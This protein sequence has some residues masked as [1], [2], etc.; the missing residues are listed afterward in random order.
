[1]FCLVSVSPAS[2]VDWVMVSYVKRRAEEFVNWWINLLDVQSGCL[3]AGQLT[4]ILWYSSLPKISHA[5]PETFGEM[6]TAEKLSS[7]VYSHSL[8]KSCS[9]FSFQ[10][11][12][13]IVVY[14]LLLC[15]NFRYLGRK[16][17]IACVM[18][19]EGFI[20]SVFITVLQNYVEKHTLQQYYNVY[21][22]LYKV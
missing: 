13:Y 21:S 14:P 10:L 8:Y 11:F 16:E 6:S 4:V 3:D 19:F 22:T 1:M 2:L 18:D 5:K 20:W 15:L 9:P 17:N 12:P 7:S